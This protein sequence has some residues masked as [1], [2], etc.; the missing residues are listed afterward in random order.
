MRVLITGATNGMG[1]G[2]AKVLAS[3]PKMELVLLGRSETL[4]RE[5]VAELRG[6]SRIT[7]VCCDLSR[8]RDVRAAITELRKLPTLDAIFV[9]AGLG[10]A[11]RHE[12]TEDGFDAHFQV[13]YLSQF[14]LTLNLLELLERSPHGGRVIFNTPSFGELHWD[15]LQ[16]KND[17]NYERAIGQAMVAKRMFAMRLHDLYAARGGAKVS[18]YGFEIAQTVWTNQINLIPTAMRAMAKAMKALGKFI[19]IEQC[20]EIMAPLFVESAEESARKSGRLITIKKGVV[21]DVEKNPMVL[22]PAAR[23]RLW[24]LSLTLCAD[25]TTTRAA[26]RLTA[27]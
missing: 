23:E 18:C 19:S 7:T 2:L 5:T 3:D 11:P 15:D 10:Y 26:A 8:L 24:Q 20:G 22:D 4:L 12:L 14:M 13:N 6:G 9:N 25:E 21:S 27:Q 17:W 16:L 1:K